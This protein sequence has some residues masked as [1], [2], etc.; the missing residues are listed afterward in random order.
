[1]FGVVCMYIVKDISCYTMY[2]MI[3]VYTH[4]ILYFAILYM[5]YYLYGTYN[6]PDDPGITICAENSRWWYHGDA[7]GHDGQ[8]QGAAAAA[9]VP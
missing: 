3:Y 2:S 7:R 6:I 1:M 9:D 8:D 4:L 5:I